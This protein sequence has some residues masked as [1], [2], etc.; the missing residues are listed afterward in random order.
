MR[1]SIAPFSESD[2]SIHTRSLADFITIMS[3]F[4]FSVHTPDKSR[5]VALA[6]LAIFQ[7]VFAAAAFRIGSH[8]AMSAFSSF[9]R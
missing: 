8:R 5:Q 9:A 4:R 1:R 3:E 6:G 2:L 7:F